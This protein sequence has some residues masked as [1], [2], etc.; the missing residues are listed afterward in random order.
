MEHITR[1]VEPQLHLVF[2]VLVVMHQRA[3]QAAI[4]PGAGGG[5]IETQEKEEEE[6][7]EEV[8]KEGE[9]ED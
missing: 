9:E 7:E 1:L 8:E 6:E 4:Q 2:L 3:G 5:R